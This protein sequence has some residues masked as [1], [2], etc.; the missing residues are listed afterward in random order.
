MGQVPQIQYG[1]IGDGRVARHLSHYFDLM[2]IPHLNW[3]RSTTDCSAAKTLAECQVVL[4]LIRDSEIENFLTQ[5][6]A[7]QTKVRV[8]FSGSLVTPLAQGVHPLMTFGND[9]YDQQTYEKMAF[10]C[11]TGTD[12]KAIFPILSNPYYLIPAQLKPYYHSLCVLGG[13]FSTVLW[14]KLFNELENA[15]GIPRD[16]A[17]PY[18]N[19]ISKNLAQNSK[20]ALTG[21]LQRRDRVT[22]QNNLKALENDEF[23]AVYQAFV[24]IAGLEGL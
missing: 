3:A 9:L 15:L 19:Q 2:Q 6:P 8:H 17:F 18:L 24:R 7:F 23:Q 12:F 5:Q 13:N 1:I 4:V 22:L 11:D 14:Q 20:G 10:V 16:A 21:P